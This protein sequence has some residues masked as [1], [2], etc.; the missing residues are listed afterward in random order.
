MSLPIYVKNRFG[1][2]TGL[3]NAAI[4]E[5]KRRV[6]VY[7]QYERIEVRNIKRLVFV[8]S[9][10]I[11]RSPLGEAIARSEGVLAESFGL[12]TRGGDP[13]D[14]RAIK[15]AADKKIDLSFHRTRQIKQYQPMDGDL[16][17]GMEP[18]HVKKLRALF[19]N[20]VPVTLAGLWLDS[21]VAYLHDP[22]N[23][24]PNFFNECPLAVEM[25]AKALA[26]KIKLAGS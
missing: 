12:D 25:S 20:Q 10:N 5:L 2:K 8:C 23:T 11:C 9:G 17:I 15:Y 14:P 26:S 16:L 4:T 7:A 6:G 22:Y 24:N 1:S 3:V 18:A 13:A 21:P 19:A